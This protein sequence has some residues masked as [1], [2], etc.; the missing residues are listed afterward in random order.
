MLVIGLTGGIGSG[1]ST[2]AKL[3]ADRGVV[4]VDADEVAREITQPS[5]PA[6]NS[7]IKHFG[8]TILQADQTLDRAQLRHLIFKDAKARLWLENLLHPIIREKMKEKIA[9][10]TGPYCLAVI[11]LLLEVEFFS[12]I[13]RILVVD[14]SA[15]QQIERVMARDN[16]IK[17]DIEAIIQ[18]QANR[19]T[20][21][22]K[23]QDVIMNDG[24][25]ADLIP[26]VDKLHQK[27]LQMAHQ[28]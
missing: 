2:V 21:R 18:T 23:A 15:H 8:N 7:I 13:N 14:A 17:T 6:F 5:E 16:M 26:Q 1:K 11:P 3:F 24:S 28:G 9:Q 20:R 4:I 27:Y 12:F 19:E 10:L 25:L 22:A